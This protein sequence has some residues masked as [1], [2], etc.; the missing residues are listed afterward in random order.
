LG[1][2]VALAEPVP[3][4]VLHR[5]FRQESAMS[6][7]QAARRAAVRWLPPS[8]DWRWRYLSRLLPATELRLPLTMLRGRAG[9]EARPAT[10]LVAGPEAALR[11]LSERFFAAPPTRELLARV[12]VWRLHSALERLAPAADLAVARVDRHFASRFSSREYLAVPEWVSSRLPLPVDLQAL[13]RGNSSV[14]EDLRKV[15][16]DAS[17]LEVARAPAD[18]ERFYADFYVPYIRNRF[19]TDAYTRGKAW[20]RHAFERGGGILWLRRDLAYLAGG[21]FQRRG[22]RLDL[23][24]IGLGDG[25]LA[26]RRKG[27]LAR[28][29]VELI[30]HATRE[31]G[32]QMGLGGSRPSLRDGVLRY[33]AKWGAV[34][35]PKRAPLYWWLVRWNRLDGAVA[36][37]LSRTPLVFRDGEALS[38]LACVDAAAENPQREARHLWMR[39][40]RRLCIVAPGIA[41]GVRDLGYAC[42]LD[43][44]AVRLGGP[45]ALHAALSAASAPAR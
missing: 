13:A 17:T 12:P 39:G 9:S 23:L 36:D 11:Y 41:S 1:T 27:L 21:L 25:N 22:Q 24:A 7:A 6:T 29:Y 15:R 30:A 37:F 10:M 3:D 16:R 14:A 26:L 5:H 43:Q 31:G 19:G 42:A 38:G 33:K 35:E 8:D 28:L 40:L 4:G 32:T 34:L 44:E 20:S 45:S 2:V 18:F